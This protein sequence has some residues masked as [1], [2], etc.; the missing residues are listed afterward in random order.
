MHFFVYICISSTVFKLSQGL[1]ACY[2]CV[3]SGAICAYS[4]YMRFLHLCIDVSN[5]RTFLTSC[6]FVE[7]YREHWGGRNSTLQ[8]EA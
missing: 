1:R 6:R 4:V 2:I 3:V 8:L 5:T 7:V